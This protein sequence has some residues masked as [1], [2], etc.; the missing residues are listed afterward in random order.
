MDTTS[1][2]DAVKIILFFLVNNSSSHCWP[3]SKIQFLKQQGWD[4]VLWNKGARDDLKGFSCSVVK[5]DL[6]PIQAIS[7]AQNSDS[8]RRASGCVLWN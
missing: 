6:M 3:I 8:D 4:V 1:K 7:R 2:F 5:M